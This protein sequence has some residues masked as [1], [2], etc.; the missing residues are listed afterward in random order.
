M[1]FSTTRSNT[2]GGTPPLSW[3]DADPE[4]DYVV[5]VR[6]GGD[7]AFSA[8][9]AAV[10]RAVERH[11]GGKLV[12]AIRDNQLAIWRR[13]DRAPLLASGDGEILLVGDLFD[14]SG[15][16]VCGEWLDRI[17]AATRTGE[18]RAC[19][20]LATA[21]GRYL[22]LFCDGGGGVT[23]LRDPIGEM[24]AY[25]T[26]LEGSWLVAPSWPDWLVEAAGARIGPDPAMV[27]HLLAHPLVA[28]D[29]SL[30]SGVSL[31]QPGVLHD[32]TGNAP[33][34]VLWSPSAIVRG[35]AGQRRDEAS[36]VL[37]RAVD[38]ACRARS[39]GQGHI[40]VQLSGGLDSAIV[41]GA[42]AQM[43][44]PERISAINF[45]TA[46]GEGDERL[47]ARAAAH[48]HGIDLI[49]R[50]VSA[51]AMDFSRL[52]STA[53]TAGP[54]LY[55]LDIHEEEM[56]IA[57]A[58]EKGAGTIM[59]GQ[60]GD[61]IFF[62]MA[63][64]DIAVDHAR[65]HGMS[66][67]FG[68]MPWIAG[69]R[70][71]CSIW[72]VWGMM[73]RDFVRSVPASSASA[74][75]DAFLLGAKARALIDP[76]LFRSLWLDGARDLAPAKRIHIDTIAN[77]RLFFSPTLRHQV[78]PV[79]HPLMT[80]PV[81]EACLS[82]TVPELAFDLR[83]RPLARDAFR[84]RLPDA[85][86]RRNGKGETSRYSNRAVVANLPFLRDYLLDG[87]LVSRGLVDRAKLDAMLDEDYLV[88]AVKARTPLYYAS[89]EAWLRRWSGR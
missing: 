53:S 44:D 74:A 32:L 16:R 25:R 41:L 77:C 75:F 79:I 42:L 35:A 64:P 89:V 40:L 68:P 67:F 43:V 31:L 26:E 47:L 5:M 78:A 46:Y 82:L 51:E 38:L 88:G 52:A 76:Q 29:H 39:A 72:R 28:V 37:R 57:V 54:R 73:L 62:Q 27:A 15:A 55:G 85:I 6:K 12:S 24:Q 69:Q 30:L 63:Y 83:D 60:G 4:L 11:G 3:S 49:E 22:A 48:H 65:D 36:A 86:Y 21:W 34:R 2:S 8:E 87:E 66:S 56:M 23:M 14:K 9:V 50:T 84:N 81:I 10:A 20:L 19:R 45:A 7:A 59:T 13:S 1:S 58:R 17:S 33:D 70:A 71:G 80:Q 61:A 18:T